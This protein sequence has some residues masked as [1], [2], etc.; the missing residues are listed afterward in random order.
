MF[1]IDFKCR[2]ILNDVNEN[3]YQK[4][5]FWGWLLCIIN[6]AESVERAVSESRS[7]VCAI[8]HTVAW[9]F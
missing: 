2:M 8:K 5:V 6:T 4:S 1:Q 7:F 9:D 3:L